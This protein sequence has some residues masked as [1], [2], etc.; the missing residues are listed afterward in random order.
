MADM[1][2]LHCLTNGV[3][4]P[5]IRFQPFVADW[6][7]WLRGRRHLFRGDRLDF[8]PKRRPSGQWLPTAFSQQP[9]TV[10]L[11]PTQ[12]YWRQVFCGG[13]YIK[14]NHISAR[15]SDHYHD[16]KPHRIGEISDHVFIT[17]D[18]W[19][20]A[21]SLRAVILS[22]SSAVLGQRWVS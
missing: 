4:L 8:R 7:I 15:A 10:P 6:P 13:R 22:R 12:P 9:A 1:I 20:S 14:G 21:L 17:L 19:S 16:R 3:S 11:S 5:S 18:G 2:E